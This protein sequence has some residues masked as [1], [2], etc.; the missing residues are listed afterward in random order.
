MPQLSR[1]AARAPH[2]WH[3]GYRATEIQCGSVRH[4]FPAAIEYLTGAGKTRAPTSSSTFAF[5]LLGL[6]PP[7]WDCRLSARSADHPEQYRAARFAG[8]ALAFPGD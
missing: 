8:R 2:Q 1:L 6:R 4:Q 3:H 7:S 5:T